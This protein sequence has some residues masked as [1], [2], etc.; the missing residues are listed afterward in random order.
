[1]ASES[2]PISQVP[3]LWT[4][5]VFHFLALSALLLLTGFAWQAM[6]APSPIAFWIAIAV[7]IAHQLFV[8][9]TWRTQLQR[10]H[11]MSFSVYLPIFMSFL[12]GRALSLIAL[13]WFDRE[14]LKLSASP[15]I[16]LTALLAIPSL[17]AMY[18]VVR[19]FGFARAA[20]GDHF[21]PR[22]RDMPLVKDGIFKFTSNGM[23]AYAFM[24]FWAIAIAFNSLAALWVAAFSHVY[25]WIHF[26]CTEKPDMAALY[27]TRASS[28]TE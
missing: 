8:W 3:S 1:M 19:Y 27:P 24:T 28:A 25:I 22:Y 9:M 16:V 23:Y 12:A 20:G 4:G 11:N 15:Q 10:R 17:Y 2:N 5:Q 6:G 21:D 7:P 14:S 18:S 26:H 13:G